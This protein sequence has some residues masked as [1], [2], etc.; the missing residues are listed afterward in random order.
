MAPE[1]RDV[2]ACPNRWVFHLYTKLNTDLRKIVM[3]SLSSRIQ[4]ETKLSAKISSPKVYEIPSLR[5]KKKTWLLIRVCQEKFNIES[6]IR[7]SQS[8]F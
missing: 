5:E 3:G 1:G 8:N 6:S 4:N 2:I 7:N